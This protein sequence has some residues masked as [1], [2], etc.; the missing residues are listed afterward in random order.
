MDSPE[1][2][3]ELI[4]KARKDARE[5]NQEVIEGNIAASGLILDQFIGKELTKIV[6]SD[7]IKP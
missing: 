6:T 4:N 7:F 3:L 1:Q 5:A 2:I